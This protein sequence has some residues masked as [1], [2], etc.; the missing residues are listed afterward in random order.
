[1]KPKYSVPSMDDVKKAK[2]SNGFTMVST[3]SGCG[4][5]CLGFEMA[6][7]DLKVENLRINL[8]LRRKDQ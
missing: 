5:S 3:F 8:A 7:F 4:G 6:G 1:M 2:G